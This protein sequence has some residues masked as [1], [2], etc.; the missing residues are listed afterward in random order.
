MIEAA[1]ASPEGAVAVVI[2][3]VVAAVEVQNT[4]KSG[5]NELTTYQADLAAATEAEAA[6][7]EVAG[8]PQEAAEHPEEAEEADQAQRCDSI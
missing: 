8:A 3:A 7:V 2:A 1:G 5:R 6:V 4:A